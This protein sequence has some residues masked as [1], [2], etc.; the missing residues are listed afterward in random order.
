MK[1]SEVTRLTSDRQKIELTKLQSTVD[2]DV[3]KGMLDPWYQ[4]L[5][6]H[7]LAVID[8]YKTTWEP[9]QKFLDDRLEALHKKHG[10]VEQGDLDDFKL[11]LVKCLHFYYSPDEKALYSV[12]KGEVTSWATCEIG[13]KPFFLKY[14]KGESWLEAKIVKVLDDEHQMAPAADDIDLM[15]V[16]P[17]RVF[18]EDWQ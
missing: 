3:L 4:D 18:D 14:G 12:V 2:E 11:T 10:E 8:Y 15:K 9:L 13:S 16:L 1:L 17:E 6:F 5:T 7:G